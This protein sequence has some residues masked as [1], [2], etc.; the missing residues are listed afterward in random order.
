MPDRY[1][2]FRRLGFE[3]NP[4]GALTRDEWA[5]IAVLPPA[6]A[7]A[8]EADP[9]H[10][11]LI[12]EKGFGKTTVLLWLAEHFGEAGE[13]V[14]YE[15][16]PEGERRFHTDLGGLDRFLLDEAQ[17][18]GGRHRARLLRAAARGLRLIVASHDDLGAAF[19]QRGLPLATVHL[20]AAVTRDHLET[21]LA[22][23]LAAFAFDDPP[24]VSLTPEAVA[25]LWE[26]YGGD[27]RASEL[28]L[29]EVFQRLDAPGAITRSSLAQALASHDPGRASR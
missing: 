23:R 20:A 7:A 17:R 13:R 1:F 19:A 25:L 21:V 4:F 5:A 3:R 11:Q 15:R 22:R 6:V 28:L 16:L 26:T 10:L 12:G 9:A 2:P 18:L 8:L 14:A 24:R 29:Y 27:L